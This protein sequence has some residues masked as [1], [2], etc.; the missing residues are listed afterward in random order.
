M[1]FE[2]EY[3]VSQYDK[4]LSL[5]YCFKRVGMVGIR[6]KKLDPVWYTMQYSAYNA[7]YMYNEII[8]KTI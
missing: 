5:L 1:I 3:N 2:N 4:N 6:L 7:I 8:L